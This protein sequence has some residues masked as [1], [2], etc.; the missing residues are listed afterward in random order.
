MVCQ[1]MRQT[2]N[3]VLI[4]HTGTL[5]LFPLMTTFDTSVIF[6]CQTLQIVCS[7]Q[8]LPSKEKTEC[9]QLKMSHFCSHVQKILTII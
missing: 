1:F 5:I 4:T 2:L 9:L 3:K 7:H 8:I 6:S